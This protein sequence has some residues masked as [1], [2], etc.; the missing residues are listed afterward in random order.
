MVPEVSGVSYKMLNGIKLPTLEEK[1]EGR[2]DN[3]S[4]L[5]CQ[6]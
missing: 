4:E 3:K 5:Q 1:K 2:P 6:E